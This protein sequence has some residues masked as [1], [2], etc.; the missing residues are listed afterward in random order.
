M[1]TAT[2]IE[3]HFALAHYVFGFRGSGRAA[4]SFLA[5]LT[6]ALI[7]FDFCLR[8]VSASLACH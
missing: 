4:S 3:Y 7:C 8:T 5:S 1:Y 6:N 2:A